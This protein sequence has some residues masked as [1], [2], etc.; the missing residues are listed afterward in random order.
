MQTN[1]QEGDSIA[2]SQDQKLFAFQV[3]KRGTYYSALTKQ[4]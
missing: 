4:Q 3:A 1:I 2:F